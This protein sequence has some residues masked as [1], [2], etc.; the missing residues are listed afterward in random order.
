MEDLFS[1]TEGRGGSRSI[2]PSARPEVNP[3][4]GSAPEGAPLAARM[5]PLSWQEVLGQAEIL[6]EL[7]GPAPS[8]G[9]GL[10]SLI[11]V[12][13]PGTGKTTIAGLLARSQQAH[14]VSLS[15]VSAGVGDIRKVV[16]EAA[17]RKRLGQ[18][19]VLFLDEIHHFS[20]TQQDA[21]LPHVESGLL[22]LIGATTENP[23]FQLTGALL[24]RVQVLDLAPLATEDLR[25]LLERALSDRERGLGRRSLRLAPASADLLIRHS[26]GDARSLLN[27]LERAAVGVSDGEEIGLEQIATALKTSHPLHD[28][29]GDLHYQVLSAF[30]KS[31][32]GSDPDASIYWLARLLEGGEDPLLPARRMIVFAAEDVGLAEPQAL[33][34]A[35][36]AHQAA[37]AVGMPECRL[38][39]SEAAIFLAL[40]PKSNSSY[41]AYS[42]AAD[43]V[44][45]HLQLPVPLH[46]R[47]AVTSRD[48]QHG[49][50]E[51]YEYA[52]DRPEGLVGHSHL[53]PEIAAIRIYEPTS[54]GR[55]EAFGIRMAE[56]TAYR[57]RKAAAPKPPPS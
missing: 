40:A 35:M 16:A 25:A 1:G 39:L 14:L 50:G 12:G 5:R 4:A 57:D 48:R 54:Q 41:R 18:A 33:P 26:G 53:P 22:T 36:A 46:L 34:L 21:L 6:K 38:P 43:L 13:P 3:N 28:R 56:I 27:T 47:N 8:S 9:V 24:S 17:A 29:A 11:L 32:R 10:P 15:A 52:H 55:E 42:R 19:T 51:G 2:G 23:S 7:G 37:A 20:R 31:M 30:I 44:S 45:Q 49:F